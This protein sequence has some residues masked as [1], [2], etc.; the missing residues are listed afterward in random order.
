M[1]KCSCGRHVRPG[2]LNAVFVY[3]RK[4]HK[5]LRVVCGKCASKT[6]VRKKKEPKKPKHKNAPWAI[7]FGK[8]PV[9]DPEEGLDE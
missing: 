2:D 6:S 7:F 9:Y 5:L 8:H 1:R 4:G 3:D